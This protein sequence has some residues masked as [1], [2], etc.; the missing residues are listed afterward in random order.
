[1]MVATAMFHA[2]TFGQLP[3]RH[4]HLSCVAEGLRLPIDA[5]F[6]VEKRY[7]VSLLLDP[8]AKGMVRTPVLGPRGSE[9]G[10]TET[11]RC[12]ELQLIASE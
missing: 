9:K 11:T 12:G 3:S 4:S 1:M 8:V 5:A 2:K 6:E 7:F 10:R